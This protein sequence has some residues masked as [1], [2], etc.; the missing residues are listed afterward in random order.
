[1][2]IDVLGVLYDSLNMNEAVEA[3]LKLM[4]KR[5]GAY[6]VTPNPEIIMLSHENAE[7]ACAID[8]A[9]LVLADG[10][11]VIYGAKILGTPLKSKL[12]GIDFADELMA[13]MALEGKSVFLFGAKPEV[14]EVA[15]K[16]LAQKH[17]GLVIAGTQDGYFSDELPIIEKINAVSPDLL[18]VCLGAPKQELFMQK[19]ATKLNVGLMA[20]LGGS[21]DVFAGNVKRAPKIFQKLGLEWFYRL[22]REP[23][24]IKRMIKLPLFLVA[25][26]GEKIRGKKK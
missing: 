13:Q 16:M 2:R 14:A 11:G 19:N 18:L 5:S 6:V 23:W 1:M 20:G 21:L 26:C 15:G 8:E 7:L 24:R 25:V 22:C 9:A 17:S 4:E 10:I 12:P 3:A